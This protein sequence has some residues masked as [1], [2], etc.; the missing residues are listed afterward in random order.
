MEYA[1]NLPGLGMRIKEGD[2]VEPCLLDYSPFG[3]VT[4]VLRVL[5]VIRQIHR[6]LQEKV[7]N[8]LLGITVIMA[9]KN[10]Y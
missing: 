4:A 5:H 6:G 8:N 3:I 2:L 7:Y 10:P 9:M 1:D